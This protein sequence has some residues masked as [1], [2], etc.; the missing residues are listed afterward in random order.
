MRLTIIGALLLCFVLINIIFI[1]NIN[2]SIILFD[3][4]YLSHNLLNYLSLSLL[5]LLIILLSGFGLFN[6]NISFSCE[7]IIFVFLLVITSYMLLSSTNLFITTFLLELIALLIFG[8]MAVSRIT[9][10]KSL[11]DS[12]NSFSKT[13]YSYGLFH[14][15]FF[16]F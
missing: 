11:I 14:S 15:L 9:I 6:Q 12:S 3:T 2:T 4:V 7:Y 10:K 1:F 16:Q 8:K 5:V 13:Q